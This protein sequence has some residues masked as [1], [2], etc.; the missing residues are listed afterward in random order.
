MMAE[1][2]RTQKAQAQGVPQS[3]TESPPQNR[4]S[5]QGAAVHDYQPADPS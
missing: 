2:Q 3:R 1:P 5:T 4:R